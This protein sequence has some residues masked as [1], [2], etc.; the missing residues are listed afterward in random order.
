MRPVTII[1]AILLCVTCATL[2]LQAQWLPRNFSADSSFRVEYLLGTQTLGQYKNTSLTYIPEPIITSSI[3]YPNPIEQLRIDFSNSQ[4]ALDGVVEITPRPALSARVRG[5]ASVF[6]ADRSFTLETG[7]SPVNPNSPGPYGWAELS[8]TIRPQFWLWEAA[9]LYNL[10]YENVYRYSIVAGYRQESWKY[11]TSNSQANSP[12]LSDV[13]GAQIPF[14]GLQTV[15]FCPSWKARFEV[16]GSAFMSKNVAHTARDQQYYMQVDGTLTNGGFLEF[17]V[18]GN[19]NVT[20][21]AWMGIY[22][23]YTYEGLKGELTGVSAS[24]T[25]GV[26]DPNYVPTP[27]N[28]YTLKNIWIIGLNCN[29]VF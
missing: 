4:L 5:S 8:T 3:P 25:N 16:L 15:M 10:S 11:R 20:P 28:F 26:P 6:N 21:S 27:Y 19:I 22:S 1:A 12:Y 9:G 24:G 7:P 2:P 23:Q 17:Q 29:F 18:E 13:F 14:L